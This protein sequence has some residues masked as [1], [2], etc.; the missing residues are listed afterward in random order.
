M[1]RYTH[2][3]RFLTFILLLLTC[4]AL[5]AQVNVSLSF[6]DE[7]SGKVIE[8]MFEM[9]KLDSG[10]LYISQ[11][12]IVTLP[13]HGLYYLTATFNRGTFTGLFRTTIWISNKNI[14]SDTLSVPK[15]LAEAPALHQQKTIYLTC[16]G[17]VEGQY[18]EY[19]ENGSIRLKG[20]FRKGV[21][22]GFVISYNKDGSKNSKLKYRNGYLVRSKHF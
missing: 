7:C 5:K 4:S 16:N 11:N 13:Y 22:N 9:S 14:F 3:M 21:A 10:S 1:K 20:D 17:L 12:G 8:G 19:Y 6:R 18:V 2:I 15:L